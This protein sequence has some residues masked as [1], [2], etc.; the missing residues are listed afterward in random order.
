MA[1]V[2]YLLGAGASF[3]R[4]PIVEDMANRISIVYSYFS[5]PSLKNLIGQ[6]EEF[7]FSIRL[8]ETIPEI[9]ID[10]LWMYEACLN[11]SSIDTFA[12]KLYL[13]NQ[14]EFLRLKRILSFYFTFVQIE[15][16]PDKRYDNFW[17][18]ILSSK[19]SIPSSIKIL[20]WNYDFQLEQSFINMSDS[21]NLRDARTKINMRNL[22][23]P[24]VPGA[25]GSFGVLKLNGSAMFTDPLSNDEF[26]LCDYNHRVDFDTYR[27]EL[28]YRYGY[29]RKLDLS[30]TKLRF[31]WESEDIQGNSLVSQLFLNRTEVLA[32]I[33]YSFPFF[34]RE[35]DK[36]LFSSM[37]NLQ[38]I[39]IQ[40]P[41]ANDIKERLVEIIPENTDFKLITGCKQFV[42]P[43]ELEII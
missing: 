8:E 27:N 14:G 24:I 32:I 11:H 39:Y 5:H 22:E 3:E 6:K 1:N 30:N 26:Y 7:S 16:T 41:Y 23:D 28:I 42:F 10:L 40:D 18:S 9:I 13:T 25:G 17:A 35:I 36:T 20:S 37:P 38:K 31:A 2:T 43:K 19:T 4:I 34:N 21:Q 33:G 12:K 15:K 29:A